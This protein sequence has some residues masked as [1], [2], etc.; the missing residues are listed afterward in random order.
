MA[1]MLVSLIRRLA[2]KALPRNEQK[3]KELLEWQG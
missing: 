1:A 2:G 3:L